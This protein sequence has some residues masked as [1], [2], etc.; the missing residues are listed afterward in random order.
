[1]HMPESYKSEKLHGRYDHDKQTLNRNW[2]WQQKQ[3]QT[4]VAEGFPVVRQPTLYRACL[5]TINNT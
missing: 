5:Y 1:M 2:K 3:L 4:L